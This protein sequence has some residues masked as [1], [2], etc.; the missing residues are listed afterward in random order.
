VTSASKKSST[1]DA[2]FFS[3]LTAKL[4][5]VGFLIQ[6]FLHFGAKW[7]FGSRLQ[8]RRAEAASKAGRSKK[9]L[10]LAKNRA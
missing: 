4:M 10:N 9:G 6:E 2:V 1:A 7:L 3:C 5:P 8:Q